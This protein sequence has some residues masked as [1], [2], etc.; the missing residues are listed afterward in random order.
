MYIVIIYILHSIIGIVVES[1][2]YTY[3]ITI[4][5]QV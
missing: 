1:Q 4:N 2:Q 3:H 5:T